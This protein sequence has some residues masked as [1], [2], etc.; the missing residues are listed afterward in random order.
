MSLHSLTVAKLPLP[1]VFSIKYWLIICS[2]VFV[3]NLRRLVVDV[4]GDSRR[5]GY[6]RITLFVE[7]AEFSGLNYKIFDDW[8]LFPLFCEAETELEDY[9]EFWVSLSLFIEKGFIV[10]YFIYTLPSEL[11][12]F[13]RLL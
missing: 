8:N 1:K 4:T 3:L 13:A 10:F 6:L 11:L 2:L 9:T 12:F 5:I 7:E